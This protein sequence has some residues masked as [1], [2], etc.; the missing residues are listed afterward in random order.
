MALSSRGSNFAASATVRAT[1]DSILARLGWSIDSKLPGQCKP[2]LITLRANEICFVLWLK[3]SSSKNC[4]QFLWIRSNYCASTG[5][6][7]S[8][9]DLRS[10]WSWWI[11]DKRTNDPLLV[12]QTICLSQVQLNQI[13]ISFKDGSFYIHSPISEV[14][15]HRLSPI[16]ISAS[17]SSPATIHSIS[18]DCSL[19]HSSPQMDI[20]RQLLNM[21]NINFARIPRERMRNDCRMTVDRAEKGPKVTTRVALALGACTILRSLVATTPA[22]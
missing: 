2:T 1:W 9:F 4:V 17:N 22:A 5:K 11:Y 18:A 19:H 10:R 7:M 8:L 13:A 6:L 15:L 21:S 16:T 12:W 20:P 14:N 3:G